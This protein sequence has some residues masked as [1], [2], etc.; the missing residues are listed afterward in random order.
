MWKRFAQ[1]LRCPVSGEGLT[2]VPFKET[3]VLITDQIAAS[4]EAAGHSRP[5]RDFCRRTEAGVLLAPSSGLLYPIARGV[6]LMHP[7]ET[8]AHAQFV[9]EYSSQLAKLRPRY[10][11]PSCAPKPCERAFLR[12]FGREWDGGGKAVG[13]GANGGDHEDRRLLTELGLRQA[14]R[15]PQILLDVGCGLGRTTAQARRHLKG[16]AIG[17]DLNFSVVTA[18]ERFRGNPLLHFVQASP[19]YLPFEPGTFDLIYSRGV[20][21]HTYDPHEALLAVAKYCRP[22][23]RFYLWVA[24][25]A[26]KHTA[27][28]RVAHAADTALRPILS[29]APTVIGT[30]MLAPF[31]LGSLG[32]NRLRR[33]RNQNLPPRTFDDALHVARDH[34]APRYAHRYDA[35]QV[36]EWF[37]EAGFEG[38]EVIDGSGAPDGL[39]GDARPNTGVR[40]ERPLARSSQ[41]SVSH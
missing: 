20:L 38:I 5:G 1:H 3:D 29:V 30:A 26:A 2:L 17:I 36:V 40:A 33:R 10:R 27:F 6:P 11:F 23:G 13:A 22:G 12:A 16:E 28:D 34:F 8:T 7:F 31:A 41:A 25:P 35:S 14:R 32:L 18:S 21:H 4:V 19:F 24:G 39:N 9:R 37:R 15:T